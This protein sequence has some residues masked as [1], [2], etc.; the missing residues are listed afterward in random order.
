MTVVVV[1]VL[2][3]ELL[4]K[5]PLKLEDRVKTWKHYALC[6][7]DMDCLFLINLEWFGIDLFFALCKNKL[8]HAIIFFH[9]GK[10]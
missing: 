4:S 9:V 7:M 10:H 2:G 8:I 6:N 1:V 5:F 3:A